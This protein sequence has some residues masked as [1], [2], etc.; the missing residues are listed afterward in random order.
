M[1][2]LLVE[3]LTRDITPTGTVDWHSAKFASYDAAQAEVGH[4]S[5]ASCKCK[6]SLSDF[7]LQCRMRLKCSA[8]D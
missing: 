5:A 3:S 7:S 4:L 1:F 8:A 6:C 2:A